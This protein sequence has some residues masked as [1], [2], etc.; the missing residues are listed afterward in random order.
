MHL[1]FIGPV[2]TGKTS[3]ARLFAKILKQKGI[4]K[5]SNIVEVGRKNLIGNAMISTSKVVEGVF[6]AARGGVL[7]IDEAYSLLDNTGSGIEAINT[8]VQEMEN[9]RD[10]VIVILGGYKDRMETLINQNEG[11]KS[12]ISDIVEFEN[13]SDEELY[14]IFEKIIR[15]NELKVNDDAKEFIKSELS[16]IIK[17]DDFDTLGN[18]RFIRKIVEKAKLNKD[19]RLGKLDK[20]EYTEDELKTIVTTDLKESIDDS[21]SAFNDTANKNSLGFI[22]A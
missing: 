17:R 11:M 3:T 21:L 16:D 13:Y 18:A 5:K 10:E 14:K 19:Y 6:Q 8:I 22:A 4:I 7:F 12:R 9:R 2:G 20:D 1:A 15:D